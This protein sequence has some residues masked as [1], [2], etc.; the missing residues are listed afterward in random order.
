MRNPTVMQELMTR[1][2]CPINL[3]RLAQKRQ[4]AK[5]QIKRLRKPDGALLRPGTR[6][7]TRANPGDAGC[8]LYVPQFTTT[9]PENH[10]PLVAQL[11][12]VIEAVEALP[13]ADGFNEQARHVY[14]TATQMVR[15]S[16]AASYAMVPA[17]G[18]L[19]IPLGFAASAGVPDDA[20]DEYYLR[21]ASKSGVAAKQTLDIAA[22]VGDR[23][24][25]EEYGLIVTNYGD[26]DQLVTAG[27]SA[28]Q[29]IMERIRIPEI[30]EVDEIEVTGTR[31][32]GFG[33]SGA[34]VGDGS[35]EATI[36]V[37]EGASPTTDA[38]TRIFT[39]NQ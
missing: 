19:I 7:P 25:P 16:I 32:G 12:S 24:Y 11:Q 37:T 15:D 36:G 9:K 38:R 26:A 8:D 23:T 39:T 6:V 35:L 14:L 29:M 2:G 20:D 13:L 4:R 31:I 17:H 3:Q 33:S 18:K 30:V 27:K 5:L 10:H 34:G 28:G 21:L 1:A 22:G